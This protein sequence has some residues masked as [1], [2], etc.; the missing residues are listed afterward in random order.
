[1]SL[2]L[3]FFGFL[4]YAH[5]LIHLL[6]RTAPTSMFITTQVNRQNVEVLSRANLPFLSSIRPETL[7][8]R[9]SESHTA[10]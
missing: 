8:F 5:R 4:A 6:I 1:M 2:F 10:F 3:D 7:V 9:S